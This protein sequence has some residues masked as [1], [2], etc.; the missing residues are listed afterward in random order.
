MLID[1]QIHANVSALRERI[2]SACRQTGREPGDVE[3]LLATKQVP[4]DRIAA[5][6]AAGVRLIGENKVQELA[7]KDEQ[8]AGVDCERHFIGHLQT[9]K[10]NHVLRYVTCIQSVDSIGLADRLQRRL[11]TL[12]QNVDVLVQVNTSGET[13]KHGVPPEEATALV[14]EIAK[15]DRLS[16]RGL[17]TIG[18]PASTPDLIRPSYRALREVRNRIREETAGGIDVSV[19]SMGMSRDLEVAIG[20]GSTMVRVGTAVFGARAR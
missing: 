2:A 7:D 15:R 11:E 20:E 16:V 9:N 6:V 8:L 18:L 4:A 10:V 12:S 17:M 13:S 1:A 5:A 3:L 19:L 14:K